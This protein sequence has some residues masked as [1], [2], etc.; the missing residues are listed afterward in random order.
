LTLVLGCVV[1]AGSVAASD[2]GNVKRVGVGVGFGLE[3][4][5]YAKIDEGGGEGL[6]DGCAVYC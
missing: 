6:L 1:C 4:V 2:G 5:A 3:D